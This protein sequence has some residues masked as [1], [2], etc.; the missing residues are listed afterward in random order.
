[1]LRSLCLSY[2]SEPTPARRGEGEVVLISGMND[3]FS[4]DP[5][6]VRNPSPRSP[7]TSE[8]GGAVCRVEVEL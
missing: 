7:S 5:G 8:S 2:S 3:R 1:M 4:G 6:A